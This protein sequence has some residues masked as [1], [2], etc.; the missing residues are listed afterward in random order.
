MP[1]SLTVAARKPGVNVGGRLAR[2]PG[3]EIALAE[4]VAV[5]EFVAGDEIGEGEDGDGVAAGDA[6]AGPGVGR[7]IAEEFDGG[8]ADGGDFG[9]DALP[10]ARAGGGGFDVGILLEAGEFGSVAAGEAEGA[11][12]E[13]TF[14]V[15][16]VEDG[17]ADAPLSGGRSGGGRP[18]R[19]WC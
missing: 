3:Q 16:D 15:G 10:G 2:G 14:G 18:L 4:D 7:E 6:G 17:L 13:D 1:R 9:E 19:R 5:V 12:G 8:L 11:V